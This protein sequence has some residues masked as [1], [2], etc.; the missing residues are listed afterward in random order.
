MALAD[1]QPDRVR[2]KVREGSKPADLERAFSL[3]IAYQKPARILDVHTT[4]SPT[5]RGDR[6]PLADRVLHMVIVYEIGLSEDADTKNA[7]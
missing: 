7:T 1:A 2:I 6:V 3:W 4:E 5:G